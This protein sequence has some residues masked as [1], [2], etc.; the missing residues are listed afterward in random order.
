MGARGTVTITLDNNTR[1]TIMGGVGGIR[2]RNVLPPQYVVDTTFE[3][4]LRVQPAYGRPYQG[5]IN[6]LEWTNPGAWHR[7]RPRFRPRRPIQRRC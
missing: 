5:M 6:T 7:T 2:L 1:G 4:T 3:P